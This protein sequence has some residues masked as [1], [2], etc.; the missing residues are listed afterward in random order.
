[1]TQIKF[2]RGSN[3]F[4]FAAVGW[5]GKVAFIKT[6]MFQ[7]NNYAV[8]IIMKQAVHAG[9]VY[10]LDFNSQFIATGGVDNKVCIWNTLSATVR[11]KLD[12]PLDQPNTFIFSLKFMKTP[13]KTLLFVLV[14]TGLLH[15]VDPLKETVKPSV[16]KLQI[17]A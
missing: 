7:K 4:W 8:P 6:P 15:V 9:D 13:Y 1:M 14:N 12:L 16:L 11:T 10:A 3:N 5:E 2:F 17:N